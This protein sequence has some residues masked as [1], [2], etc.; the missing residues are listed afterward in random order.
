MIT[1]DLSNSNFSCYQNLN[2]TGINNEVDLMGLVG[3]N[4][5]L[6]HDFNIYFSNL[7]LKKAHAS[8]EINI[9][10]SDPIQPSTKGKIGTFHR[11][12]NIVTSTTVLNAYSF[13]YKNKKI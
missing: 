4:E 12:V 7:G 13:S 6:L 10:L 1:Y 9:N 2:F 11:G 8:D 5:R 3:S